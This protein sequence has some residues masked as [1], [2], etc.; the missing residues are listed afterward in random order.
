M[1]YPKRLIRLRP[2]KGV[3]S[4]LPAFAQAPDIFQQADNIVFRNGIANRAPS[5]A[6]V[7]DPP[8]VAPL[9]TQN[10]QI[11][12]VNY[13]IYAGATASYAVNRRAK[14]P[15]SSDPLPLNWA[16]NA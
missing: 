14:R 8:S 7:Y 13:W 12:N 4:D 6:A 5:V 16:S 1:S 10:V 15:T 2:R 9:I 3:A 11:E